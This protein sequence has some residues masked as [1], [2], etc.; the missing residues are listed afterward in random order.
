LAISQDR[1]RFQEK[2]PSLDGDESAEPNHMRP[3]ERL[4]MGGMG[5]EVQTVADDVH[6]GRLEEARELSDV[7]LGRPAVADHY[8][9]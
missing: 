4:R 9:G 1:G 5:G 8:P 6:P 3:A 7:V 2:V